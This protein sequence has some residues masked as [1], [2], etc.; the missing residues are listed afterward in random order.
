MLKGRWG[1][2]Y[3][4]VNR[5]QNQACRFLVLILETPSKLCMCAFG[6]GKRRGK[7]VWSN[8]DFQRDTHSKRE[9]SQ[10]WHYWHFGLD[11][12]L[13]REFV[14]SIVECSASCLAVSGEMPVT[15]PL[16]AVRTFRKVSS[17]GQM[18]LGEQSCPSFEKF[19]AKGRQKWLGI[20]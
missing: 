2:S 16:P 7:W 11:N 13:L 3:P 5:W 20:V 18:S 14:P 6:Q 1:R 4:S 15:S 12:S 17:H 8:D 9:A 19:W 10:P